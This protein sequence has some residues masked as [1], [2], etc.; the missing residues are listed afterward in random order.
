MCTVA[1]NACI[2]KKEINIHKRI[3]IQQ[4][5]KSFSNPYNNNIASTNKTYFSTPCKVFV[6][7][8]FFLQGDKVCVYYKTQMHIKYASCGPHSLGV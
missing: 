7:I 1:K 2:Y 4:K 6:Q 5:R 3:I 8:F